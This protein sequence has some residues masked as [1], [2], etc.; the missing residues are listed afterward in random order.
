MKNNILQREELHTERLG[1]L[2][3]HC[4]NVPQSQDGRTPR[5]AGNL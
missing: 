5:R 1:T 2:M 4:K 3:G